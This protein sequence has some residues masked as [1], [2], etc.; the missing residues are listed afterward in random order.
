MCQRSDIGCLY[1]C[2]L[3]NIVSGL[4]FVSVL[5]FYVVVLEFFSFLFCG[6]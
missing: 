5:V 1:L 2:D 3:L 4:S 6:I